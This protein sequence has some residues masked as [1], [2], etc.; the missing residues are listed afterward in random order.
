MG[1]EYLM[2]GK[3]DIVLINSNRDGI[4]PLPV[5][6]SGSYVI[7]VEEVCPIREK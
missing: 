2:V 3:E 6:P 1:E 4:I 7:C 5:Y